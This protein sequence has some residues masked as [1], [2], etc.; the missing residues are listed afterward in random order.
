[1]RH[2]ISAQSERLGNRNFFA[3]P[4]QHHSYLCELLGKPIKHG[5]GKKLQVAGLK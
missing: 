2:F 4:A 1:M 5:N 3:E